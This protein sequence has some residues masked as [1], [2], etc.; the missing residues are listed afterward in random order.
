MP[1]L[2]DTVRPLEASLV[3]SMEQMLE[4]EAL[5][6]LLEL[7]LALVSSLVVVD[8]LVVAYGENRM[9]GTGSYTPRG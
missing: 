6:V 1:E 7:L 5:L 2:E 4:E 8:I 9:E 3:A